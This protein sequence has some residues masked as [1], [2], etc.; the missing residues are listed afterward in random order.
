M[1]PLEFSGSGIMQLNK[2]WS[3]T[4]S[5][6]LLYLSILY[7]SNSY[8]TSASSHPYFAI[9]PCYCY[10]EWFPI[11]FSLTLS[12]II[13]HTCLCSYHL[14]Q[15]MIIPS[16]ISLYVDALRTWLLNHLA[17]YL[18]NILS[19]FTAIAFWTGVHVLK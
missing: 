12:H 8:F 10:A 14:S 6:M 17:H 4:S 15:I 2:Y 18:S 7:K 16:F 13:S 5:Y 19:S 1:N 9:I 11:A 3:L